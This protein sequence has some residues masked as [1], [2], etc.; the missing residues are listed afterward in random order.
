MRIKTSKQSD[1]YLDIMQKSLKFSTKAALARIAIGYSIYM[2]GDPINDPEFFNGDT[3]GFE[4][5]RATLTADYDQAFKVMIVQ[6]HGR[7]MDDSIYY[8]RALK[9]HLD[10][11][12]KHLY[13]EFKYA[14]N[15]EKFFNFL[16]GIQSK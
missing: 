5:Q 16:L 15:K 11:G 13:S 12:I 4:F 1:E 2:E 14:G 6:K 7:P 8:P 9:A 10:R 3:Q